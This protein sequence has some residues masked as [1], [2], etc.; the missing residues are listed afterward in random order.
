MNTITTV[1]KMI[2]QNCIEKGVQAQT[3]TLQLNNREVK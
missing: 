1:L 2:V 3:I